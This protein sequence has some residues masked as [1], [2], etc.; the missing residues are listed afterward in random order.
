MTR[1]LPANRGRIVWHAKITVAVLPLILFSC[2]TVM[3]RDPLPGY[4]TISSFGEQ[5]RTL[6]F[7]SG[8]KVTINAGP[9]SKFDWGAPVDL[10]FYALPNGNTT[11]QTIGKVVSDSIDWH[12]GI[13]HIGA[14]T[15]R[16]REVMAGRTIVVAYLEAP[17]LSWPLWRRQYEGGS[18]MI[19]NIVDSIA[20]LMPAN[21][22]RITLSGHSGGGSFVFGYLN[23]VD[24]IPERVRRI[25]FLDS[26]YGY[27]AGERHGEKLIAWLNESSD[28]CLSVIAY[29]DR[30]ITLNGKPVIGPDGGTYRRTLEM[31]EA[32][33]KVFVLTDS[34]RDNIRR[35]R[36]LDGRIDILLHE[37][38][39]NRILHTTLVGEMNGFIQAMTSGTAFEGIAGLFNGP[40][41]YKKWIAP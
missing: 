19:R 6:T 5:V 21:D 31:K 16:L 7:D 25:S 14:Q 37:N 23:S 9:A 29:D 17:R 3:E 38:P 18:P 13:Q 12:F 22:V 32:L 8:V 1:E 24:R 26:N 34:V 10:V 40:I 27:S 36:G 15:R 41:A 11:E 39:E 35:F 20:S 30:N 2:S 4:S 33:Q 28:H